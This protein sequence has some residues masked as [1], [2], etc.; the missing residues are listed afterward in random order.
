MTLT[1]ETGMATALTAISAGILFL[2]WPNKELFNIPGFI[3]GKL[4][5]N[6]LLRVLNGRNRVEWTG[7]VVTLPVSLESVSS[8][9]STVRTT[10]TTTT[11]A[12]G[13]SGQ[14]QCGGLTC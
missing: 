4:Y 10:T 7:D 12:R 6:S 14:R 2:V 9:S 1:I 3:L 13:P 11:V 5:S 8:E